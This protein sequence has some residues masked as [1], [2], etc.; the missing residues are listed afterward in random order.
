MRK[1]TWF[2]S[3]VPGRNKPSRAT[4]RRALKPAVEHLEQRRVLAADVLGPAIEVAFVQ[5]SESVLPSHEMSHGN[6]MQVDRMMD[7]LLNGAGLK[8]GGG[9]ARSL[10]KAAQVDKQESTLVLGNIA[11]TPTVE[12]GEDVIIA[13]LNPPGTG[14]PL[15]SGGGQVAAMGFGPGDK[16]D[17]PGRKAAAHDLGPRLIKKEPIRQN[18]TP[19]R[20]PSVALDSLYSNYGKWQGGA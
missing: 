5:P 20:G 6:Q 18:A 8:S 2:G 4:R 13:P 16:P 7:G 10:P 17:A 9:L 14:G 11:A 1:R 15:D 12:A 3:Y 19:K